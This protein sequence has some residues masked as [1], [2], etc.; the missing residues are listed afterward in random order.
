MRVYENSCKALDVMV[1][2]QIRGFLP[3]DTITI[4]DRA[5]SFNDFRA[6]ATAIESN[7]DS[8]T[9]REVNLTSAPLQVLCLALAKCVRLT[10]LVS[11]RLIRRA[12]RVKG[13]VSF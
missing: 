13:I 6:F 10:F 1:D 12:M 5:F 9:L 2:W 7:L 3:Y 4:V 8:L 11:E